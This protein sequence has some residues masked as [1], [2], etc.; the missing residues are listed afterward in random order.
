MVEPEWEQSS[1]ISATQGPCRKPT[2]EDRLIA[3]M[4]GRWLDEELARGLGASFSEANAA[5][6]QQLTAERTRKAAARRLDRLVDRAEN[7]RPASLIAPRPPC[8]EQVRNAMP[9]ILTFRSQLLS[10]E[11]LASEGIARLKILL[12]DRRGPCYVPSEPDALMAALQEIVPSL[13]VGETPPSSQQN[14]NKVIATRSA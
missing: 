14:A 6:A 8:R 1:A 12:A 9:L 7:P 2:L 10:K 4:L 11:P 13:D 5:R 3:R